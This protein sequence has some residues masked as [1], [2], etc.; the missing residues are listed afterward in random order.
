M[1][2]SEVI[3]RTP[4]S[5]EELVK[6]FLLVHRVATSGIDL[7]EMNFKDVKTLVTVMNTAAEYAGF[8][9]VIEMN[10]FANRYGIEEIYK[11]LF[12]NPCD[13]NEWANNLFKD[14]DEFQK[15]K[16]GLNG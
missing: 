2:E 9:D 11:K 3:I 15:F 13:N 1:M 8:K 7:E 6:S 16:E 14:G 4:V 12:E 10:T 5:K